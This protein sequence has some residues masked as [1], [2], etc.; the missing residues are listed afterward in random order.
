MLYHFSTIVNWLSGLGQRLQVS[1]HGFDSHP[2]DWYFVPVHSELA[3]KPQ[4]LVDTIARWK[5]GP[6][7]SN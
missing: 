7:K 2:V 3:E 5:N 4:G 1:D 6:I